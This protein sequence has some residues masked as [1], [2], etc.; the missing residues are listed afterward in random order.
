MSLNKILILLSF[1]ICHSSIAQ[2]WYLRGG[3][4]AAMCVKRNISGSTDMGNYVLTERD[5]HLPRLRGS[6]GASVD[7]KL[8][9]KLGL[10]TG[11]NL[12]YR[13]TKFNTYF[14]TD[15]KTSNYW[16]TSYSFIKIHTLSAG[17]PL[18]LTIPIHTGKTK[19]YIL[20]GGEVDAKFLARSQKDRAYISEHVLSIDQFRPSG[21][22]IGNN[23]NH[24]LRRINYIASIGMGLEH[25]RF[26]YELLFSHGINNM[27]NIGPSPY[28]V[29]LDLHNKVWRQTYLG[30]SVGYLLNKGDE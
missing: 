22:G 19:K 4:G 18:M 3:P 23:Y 6:L 8:G 12:N 1:F 5:I 7:F 9:A 15:Y 20:V 21:L 29:S 10:R 24:I 25:K 28:D 30:F 2:K 27:I 13:G 11:I 17:V 16:Y 26:Q 14:S